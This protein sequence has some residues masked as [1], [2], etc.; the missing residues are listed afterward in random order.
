MAQQQTLTEEPAAV[1]PEF[2]DVVVSVAARLAGP[3]PPSR[4]T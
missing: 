1:Q 4:G 3:D 2:P